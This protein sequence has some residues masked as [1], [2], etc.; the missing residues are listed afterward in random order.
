MKSLKHNMDESVSKY[1]KSLSPPGICSE[2]R[3]NSD[4]VLAGLFCGKCISKD[5]ALQR[6]KA[7]LKLDAIKIAYRALCT[8][9]DS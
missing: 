8:D 6:Y 1:I 9:Y 5:K 7:N 2:C 4:E 3:E